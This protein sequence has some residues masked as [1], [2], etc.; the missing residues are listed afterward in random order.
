MLTSAPSDRSLPK[1]WPRHV[2]SAVLQVIALAHMALTRARGWCLNCRVTRLRL[3]AELDR[4]HSEI[5]LLREEICI[6]DARMAKIDPSGAPS[7]LPPHAWPSW[8]CAPRGA[9]R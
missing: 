8:N 9:G 3:A 6:K 5:S 2:R 7:T 1:D 4:A